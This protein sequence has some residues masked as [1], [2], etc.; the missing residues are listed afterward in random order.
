MHKLKSKP[1]VIQCAEIKITLSITEHIDE[2]L[3]QK[4]THLAQASA[5]EG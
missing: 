1:E 2:A 3:I 5:D 4:V